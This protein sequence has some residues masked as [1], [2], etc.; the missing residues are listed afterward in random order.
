MSEAMFAEHGEVEPARLARHVEAMF[1]MVA[2]ASWPVRFGLRLALVL[3]RLAPLVLFAHART[4]ERLTVAERVRVL[5]RVER[6]RLMLLCLAFVGWRTIATLVVYEHP[7]EL[8]ALGY[9]SDERERHKRVLRVLPPAEAPVPLESGVRLVE[10]EST[11]DS[12]RV[13]VA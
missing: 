3:L 12:G 13:E 7:D 2:V 11:P 10:G 8:R 4:L 6:S 5:E 1:A 9:T